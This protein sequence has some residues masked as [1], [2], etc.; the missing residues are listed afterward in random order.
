M[1]KVFLGNLLFGGEMAISEVTGGLAF[2]PCAL[3]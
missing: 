1:G 2:F 3:E